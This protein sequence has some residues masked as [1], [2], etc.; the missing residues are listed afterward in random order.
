M[1]DVFD[2]CRELYLVGKLGSLLIHRCYNV[3]CWPLPTT[4]QW[5]NYYL[6]E[7]P[8]LRALRLADG[9]CNHARYQKIISNVI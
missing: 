6:N 2:H 9:P 1:L 4:Y 7:V 5:V 3:F 8:H